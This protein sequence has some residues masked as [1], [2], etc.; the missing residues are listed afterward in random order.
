MADVLIS[1]SDEEEEKLRALAQEL[2]GGKR[3]SLSNVVSLAL[4]M[5]ESSK[6]QEKKQTLQRL[7][8]TMEEGYSLAYKEKKVYEKRAELYE[9][10]FK[11]FD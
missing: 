5:V 6:K 9:H 10:R 7:I 4:S 1:L 8:K 11:N 3:G 2:Y